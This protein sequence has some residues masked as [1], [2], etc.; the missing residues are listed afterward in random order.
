MYYYNDD[1]DACNIS[2]NLNDSLAMDGCTQIS[3]VDYA[4]SQLAVLARVSQ[5]V[6]DG[7][8][9]T[10]DPTTSPTEEPSV[11]PTQ[12]PTSMDDGDDAGCEAGDDDCVD[13]GGADAMS[14]SL[15]PFVRVLSILL[16]MSMLLPLK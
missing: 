10:D 2:T 6:I 13:G 1:D 8:V 7:E 9:F 3:T 16:C 12:G 15:S 5:C 4:G 14:L 11:M